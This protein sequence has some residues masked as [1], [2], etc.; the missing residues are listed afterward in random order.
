[1]AIF[2]KLQTSFW[3]DAAN[4]ELSK[5]EQ[6]L[7][8]YLLT[9]EYTNLAGVFKIMEKTLLF[10]TLLKPKELANA[11]AGLEQKGKIIYDRSTHEVL[12]T[13]WHAVCANKSPTAQ[14]SA[15]ASLSGVRSERLKDIRATILSGAEYVPPDNDETA[16]PEPEAKPPAKEYVA[17]LGHLSEVTGREYR[18][19]TQS[20][21]KLIRTRRAENKG[22]KLADFIAVIDVK[23]KQ[24]LKTE[25]F[26]H[27]VRPETL[28]GTKFPTYLAEASQ[29][30]PSVS[31]VKQYRCP[32]CGTVHS[33]T[34]SSV[35]AKCN[36]D[37]S[38]RDDIEAVDGYKEE[39]V[40]AGFA[41][42]LGIVV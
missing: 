24:W 10:E 20:Y 26:N 8:C 38:R 17:I 39:M 31:A 13:Q 36:F 28:F 32:V 25:D 18:P 9:N 11:I 16:A 4:D 19:T 2:R 3:R 22:L 30:A 34:N 21:Q 15:E 5:D 7:Y 12:V 1:M 37:L 27:L 42:R 35:C 23:A 40:E 33:I 29:K 14:K 41:E 6:H